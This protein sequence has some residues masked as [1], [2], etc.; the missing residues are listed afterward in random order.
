MGYVREFFTNWKDYEGPAS[1][2]ACVLLRAD[3]STLTSDGPLPE[4]VYAYRE[5]PTSFRSSSMPAALGHA[6]FQGVQ[7]SKC[8]PCWTSK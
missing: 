5:S 2:K 6:S 4:P 1:K 3:L 7:A 8:R